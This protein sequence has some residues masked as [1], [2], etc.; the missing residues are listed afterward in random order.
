MGISASIDCY[1]LNVVGGTLCRPSSQLGSIEKYGV[2]LYKYRPRKNQKMLNNN[3]DAL[4]FILDQC[5]GDIPI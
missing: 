2:E 4:I 3:D 1:W 5:Q